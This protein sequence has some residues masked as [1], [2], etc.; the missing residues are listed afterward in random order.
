MKRRT[1]SLLA[2]LALAPLT[3]AA[4]PNPRPER[5]VDFNREIRPIL[6][7]TCFLCHGPDSGSRQA[8]LRLDK[9][10]WD[11]KKVLARLDAPDGSPL[12]MPPA[13]AHK[14]LSAS[15]KSLLRRWIASGAKY[16]KHWSL[17][18]LPSPPA[19]SSPSERGERLSPSSV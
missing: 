7:G 12:Q 11:A 16:E 17:V 13:S 3:L 1:L 18:S 6:A 4:P 10:G 2:P 8:G 15:Q 5:A 19:P 9:P 14:P